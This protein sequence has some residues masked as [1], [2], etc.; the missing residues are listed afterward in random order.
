ML[1]TASSNWESSPHRWCYL[2]CM[3]EGSHEWKQK[4][5]QRA[6]KRVMITESRWEMM[7]VV[8][9]KVC[10]GRMRNCCGPPCMKSSSRP[11]VE[12]VPRSPRTPTFSSLFCALIHSCPCAGV[13]FLQICPN[14]ICSL[15]S[16]S[17]A[18]SSILWSPREINPSISGL[19]FPNLPGGPRPSP[20]CTRAPCVFKF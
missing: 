4:Q 9:M 14:L 13:S 12:N 18:S 19:C 11:H 6:S 10:L 16:C 5:V 3:S 2:M 20:S 7:M 1:N 15:K 17:L 8:T